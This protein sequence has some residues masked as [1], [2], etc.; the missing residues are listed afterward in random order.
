VTPVAVWFTNF[1]RDPF[2]VC[3]Q[4]RTATQKCIGSLSCVW[5][6]K[7]GPYE[8]ICSLMPRCRLPDRQPGNKTLGIGMVEL[9]KN[10]G[11]E[12]DTRKLQ[13]VAAESARF[14]EVWVVRLKVF[15]VATQKYG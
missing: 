6:G 3:Q 14:D 12:L 11:W 1:N 8:A 9:V 13:P 5:L 7:A 10:L 2:D 4:Q 15:E